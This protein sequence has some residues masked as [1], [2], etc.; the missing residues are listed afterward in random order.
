MSLPVRGS[1]VAVPV[2]EVTVFDPTVAGP[3]ELPELPE[4]PDVSANAGD[5]AS[6]SEL[7]MPTAT[8]T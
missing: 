6:K 4:L 7:P 2:V 8:A 1:S 5:A 3:P